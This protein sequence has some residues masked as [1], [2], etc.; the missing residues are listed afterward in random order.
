MEDSVIDFNRYRA[1]EKIVGNAEENIEF[2]KIIHDI[3]SQMNVFRNNV[4]IRVF[5]HI[6]SVIIKSKD[7][8]TVKKMDKISDN[9]S[10]EDAD[11]HINI[12]TTVQIS[13][14]DRSISEIPSEITLHI[15]TDM[16]FQRTSIGIIPIAFM[17]KVDMNDDTYTN[18]IFA[19][20]K[21]KLTL[22]ERYEWFKRSI[23]FF[24]EQD[25]FVANASIMYKG[26]YYR[27]KCRCAKEDQA[28]YNTLYKIVKEN[29]TE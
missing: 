20:Y 10:N 9:C 16:S 12:D 4:I 1:V 19:L 18:L 3:L 11:R 28:K 7:P 14:T 26:N 5:A 2:I 8:D 13:I 23:P 22:K 17:T 25:T 15:T 27:F 29:Y 24:V 6:A 21:A